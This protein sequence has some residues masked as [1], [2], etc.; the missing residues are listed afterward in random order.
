MVVDGL[1]GKGV[2]GVGCARS[3]VGKLVLFGKTGFVWKRLDW[4]G[5]ARRGVRISPAASLSV[6]SPYRDRSQQPRQKK[7]LKNSNCAA[8]NFSQSTS[9]QHLTSLQGVHVFRAFTERVRVNTQAFSRC[10]W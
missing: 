9:T 1:G 4:K 7:F 5:C 10:R 2:Q 3:L 8:K 6:D